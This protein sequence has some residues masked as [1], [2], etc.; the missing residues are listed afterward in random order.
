VFTNL[1]NLEDVLDGSEVLLCVFERD[2]D[3]LGGNKIIFPVSNHLD[4][5]F[6][7]RRVLNQHGPHQMILNKGNLPIK[8][9]I[10][11]K[12]QIFLSGISLNLRIEGVPVE[13][14]LI[15]LVFDLELFGG[16]VG[17]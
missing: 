4:K 12:E 13:G 3:F 7:K 10:I 11:Q 1:V 9:S 5:S 15:L 8:E 14:H 2:K 6:G 17:N 16:L